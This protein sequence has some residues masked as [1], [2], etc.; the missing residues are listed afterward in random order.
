MDKVD[1]RVSRYVCLQLLYS[2]EMSN[3]SQKDIINHFYINSN[4][5]YDELSEKQINYI[6]KI[7]DLCKKYKESI[8]KLINTKLKNWDMSRLALMDKL[9]LRMAITEMLY[10]DEVP[11]KVSITE[12]VEIAKEFSTKDSS[13]FVN[14]ILDAV[15]NNVVKKNIKEIG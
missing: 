15:Y 2:L 13:R 14:G 10:V 7:I 12:G 1:K 4:E 5:L 9:I 8:D 11:P 6:K 3:A